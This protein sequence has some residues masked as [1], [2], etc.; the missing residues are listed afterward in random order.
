MVLV[1]SWVTAVLESNSQCLLL[2]IRRHEIF[3]SLSDGI[4]TQKMNKQGSKERQVEENVREK[5]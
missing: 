2:N 5:G 4:K 3:S 1:K